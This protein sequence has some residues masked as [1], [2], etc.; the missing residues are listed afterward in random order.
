[1]NNRDRLN[2]KIQYIELK[3]LFAY[4]LPSFPG[5]YSTLQQMLLD[6]SSNIE[7][8]DLTSTQSKE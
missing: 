7:H 6:I 4:S 8:E 5:H 1:M 3:N 2:N